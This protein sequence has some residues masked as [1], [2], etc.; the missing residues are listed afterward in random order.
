[1]PSEATSSSCVPRSTM[2]PLWTT[3]IW[4]ALITVESRCAMRTTVH[5]TSSMSLS[6]ACWTSASFSASSAEVASSRKS[7]RGRRRK[8]RAMA[9][10]CRWPPD[11]SMPRSPTRVSYCSSVSMM[12]SWAF[13]A[14][15]AAMTSSCV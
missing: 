8:Q 2:P 12:N 7:S 3:A 4:L 15:Q 10:R 14:L 11:S 9:K 13:A 5:F 6:S 1:M